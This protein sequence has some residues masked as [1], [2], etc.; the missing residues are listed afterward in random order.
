MASRDGLA[1]SLR[2]IRHGELLRVRGVAPRR[3]PDRRAVTLTTHTR[4][5]PLRVG[6][7][8]KRRTPAYGRA[9]AFGPGGGLLATAGDNVVRLWQADSLA[10]RGGLACPGAEAVAFSPGGR[11]L[12]AKGCKRRP[13]EAWPEVVR[14]W[15]VGADGVIGGQ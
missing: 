6:T 8:V 2:G 11:F 12:A 15:S 5:E 4:T 9:L 7:V 13:D 14:I 1:T 10:A 3:G